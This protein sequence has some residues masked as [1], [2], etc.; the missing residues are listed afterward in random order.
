MREKQLYKGEEYRLNN[1]SIIKVTDKVL[2]MHRFRNTGWGGESP[3]WSML[4]IIGSLVLTLILTIIIF[5]KDASLNNK[6]FLEFLLVISS[7]FIVSFSPIILIWR[8]NRPICFN[9]ERQKV[10][11]WR[12]QEVAEAKWSD[13]VY[14]YKEINRGIY[15]ATPIIALELRGKRLN[16]TIYMGVSDVDYFEKLSYIN[17]FMG[18]ENPILSEK[19]EMQIARGNF[20][21]SLKELFLS[22]FTNVPWWYLPYA[23][24]FAF[25]TDIVMYTLN[26]ILPMRGAPKKLREACGIPNDERVY[27]NKQR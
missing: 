22:R 23:F 17:S 19:A 27:G 18:G 9:R 24:F 4:M 8:L 25:P 26:K 13:K 3:T 11:Y 20:Q 6:D 21:F 5:D 16:H 15:G 10:Y 1:A 7:F 2:Y 12:G 14:S